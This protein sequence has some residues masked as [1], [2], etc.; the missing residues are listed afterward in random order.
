MISPYDVAVK[1]LLDKPLHKRMSGN[2]TREVVQVLAREL[3]RHGYVV[4]SSDQRS[5][6]G[7]ERSA[8]GDGS[9]HRAHPELVV[10]P[11]LR[12]S[13][14]AA[15]RIGHTGGNPETRHLGKSNNPTDGDDRP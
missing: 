6:R 10:R 5:A 4:I 14:T 15:R 12:I 1:E 13:E 11:D 9:L 7:D 8:R 2:G 3:P